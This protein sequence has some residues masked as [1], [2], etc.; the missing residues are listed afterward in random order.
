MM[1]AS[2]RN[3]N[4][5]IVLS[6]YIGAAVE[7][8]KQSGKLWLNRRSKIRFYREVPERRLGVRTVWNDREIHNS[9]N[10]ATTDELDELEA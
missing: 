5:K 3:L 2:R 7:M 9:N 6:I 10:A 8:M 4:G 1:R